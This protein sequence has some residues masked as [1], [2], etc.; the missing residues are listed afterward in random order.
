[1]SSGICYIHDGS[2]KDLEPGM[3]FCTSNVSDLPS[4]SYFFVDIVRLTPGNPDKLIK[5]YDPWIGRLFTLCRING[6]WAS[7]WSV[8]VLTSDLESFGFPDAKSITDL[9]AIY[10]SCFFMYNVGA[11]NAP[12]SDRGGCGVC[13]YVS[14]AWVCLL[15]IPYYMTD[16]HISTRISGAWSDWAKK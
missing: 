4:E 7:S 6:N 9:H 8:E 1:M 15:V 5:A 2:V 14:S 16:L 12:L 10:Q 3:Y 11:A 13:I